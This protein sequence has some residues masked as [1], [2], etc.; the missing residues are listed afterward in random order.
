MDRVRD[1]C[2]A[3]RTLRERE[4][5]RVRQPLA[6][7][8]LAGFGVAELAPYAELLRDEVNVK[9]V[10]FAAS[11]EEFASFQLQANARALGPRLGPEMKT[12][13]AAAKQGRWRA[14]PDGRAEVAGQ[15]L[16]PGEF[17]LRLVPKPGV[18]AEPLPSQDAIAVLD[19]ALDDA[20]VREGIARDVIRGVQQARKEAGLHVSDRIRLVLAPPPAWREAVAEHLDAIAEQT[21]AR[22]VAVSEVL[23]PGLARHT[24]SFGDQTLAIGLARADD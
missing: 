19:L 9:E 18:A 15:T 14:L 20:L 24:A 4:N 5:V 12:V 13:L 6:S 11:I 8:T 21:L 1:A 17:Q 22:H 3:A 2:S 10:R 16:E 23:E 7:L